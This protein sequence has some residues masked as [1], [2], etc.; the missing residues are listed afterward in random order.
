MVV[1]VRLLGLGLRSLS[2]LATEGRGRSPLPVVPL[3][4]PSWS[5]GLLPLPGIMVLSMVTGHR[6]LSCLPLGVVTQGT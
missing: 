1:G 2:L 3:K 5:G 4:G 6:G